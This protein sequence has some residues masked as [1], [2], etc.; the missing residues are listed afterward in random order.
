MEVN[1]SIVAIVGE[2]MKHST[3]VAGKLFSTIGRNGI[4]VVAIAQGASEFNI[5]WVVRNGDLR[6]TLNVVH[7]SFFLSENVQLNL[8]LI[9]TGLV[10]SHLLSQI[11]GQQERLLRESHLNIRLAGIANRKNMLFDRRNRSEPL[12]RKSLRKRR[13]FLCKRFHRENDLP[14]HV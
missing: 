10:G 12:C 13:T 1:L 7:E 6:K 3:G 5:S 2:N 11:G 9:G 8:F 14:E 4:N